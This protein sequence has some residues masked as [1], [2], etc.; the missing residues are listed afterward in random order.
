MI[1]YSDI[2]NAIGD[3]INDRYFVSTHE[4][5][6][7]RAINRALRDINNGRVTDNPRGAQKRRVG[8]DWQRESVD[9]VYISGTERYIVSTVITLSELKY[10]SDVLIDSDENAKFNQRTASYFR[11]RRG[12]NKT[13]ERMWANEFIGG[14]KDILIYNA[15]SDT[16]NLIWYSNFMVL[17]SDGSTRQELFSGSDDTEESLL[18]QDDYSDSI[19]DI[20]SGYLI[21]QDRTEQSAG[22]ADLL[23]QGR[24]TLQDLINA[25]GQR[26]KKPVDGPD[27]NSEWG[28]YDGNRNR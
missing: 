3:N 2:T 12:V 28:N 27:I 19:V 9:L 7:K 6:I 17:D 24:R 16:L 25:H 11:R 22:P 14:I 5:E 23:N 10:I 18:M 8:Y 4:N 26:E 15:D 20:A 13:T 21:K 1:K